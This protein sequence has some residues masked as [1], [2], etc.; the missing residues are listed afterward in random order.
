MD[1]IGWVLIRPVTP[2]R[3]S[4]ASRRP[5]GMD[6]RWRRND[7]EDG[8]PTPSLYRSAMERGPGGG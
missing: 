3:H 8:Q 2:A 7:E 6:S 4:G 5:V 1:R